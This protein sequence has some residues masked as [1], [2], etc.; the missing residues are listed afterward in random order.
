VIRVGV[1]R[2]MPVTVHLSRFIKL[3][4]KMCSNV[5]SMIQLLTGTHFGTSVLRTPSPSVPVSKL[6]DPSLCVMFDTFI[7]IR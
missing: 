1:S 6:P 5:W 4:F 3:G 7:Q 2:D